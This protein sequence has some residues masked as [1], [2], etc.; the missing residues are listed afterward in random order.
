MFHPSI[1]CNLLTFSGL[2][3]SW[4]QS[5]LILGEQR[6][7]VWIS[8]QFITGLTYGDKQPFT[9]TD[10]FLF[11]FGLWEEP[12]WPRENPHRHKESTGRHCAP[13]THPGPSCFGATVLTTVPCCPHSGSMWARTKQLSSSNL[14]G[15]VWKHPSLVLDNM[16]FWRQLYRQGWVFRWHLCNT[17]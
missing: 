5:Q 15:C 1:V 9:P 16:P 12:W 4:N 7:T 6:G 2:Q 8:C 3:G 11:V 14:R 10:S 13:D 17:T